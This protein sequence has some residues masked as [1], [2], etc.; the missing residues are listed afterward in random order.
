M[1]LLFCYDGPILKDENENY[2]GTAL[3]DEM[4]ERYECITNDLTIAIRVNKV[5]KVE[6]KCLR[7]TKEKYKVVEWNWIDNLD[8]KNKVY[9]LTKKDVIKY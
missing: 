9:Y 3:N 1:K 6:N 4:F 8:K 2:Y 7:I 5:E